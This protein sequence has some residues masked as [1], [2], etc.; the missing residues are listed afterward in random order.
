MLTNHDDEV[1]M[2]RRD[3]EMIIP[4][5]RRKMIQTRRAKSSTK[6]FAF[7]AELHSKY[8]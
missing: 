6:I 5:S 2:R 7:S 3:A 4:I 8:V 1:E